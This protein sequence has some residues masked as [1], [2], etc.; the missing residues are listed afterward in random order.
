MQDGIRGLLIDA[1]F[2]SKIH[3]PRLLRGKP[4]TNS[5]RATFSQ[6]PDQHCSE[7]QGHPRQAKAKTF[8]PQKG[9]YRD[10]SADDTRHPEV[11]PGTDTKE[12]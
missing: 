1:L 5:N 11:G 2:L 10:M 12:I 3:F 7:L 8:P 6:M 9:P 4:Q